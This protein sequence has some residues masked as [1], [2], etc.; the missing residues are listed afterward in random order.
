LLSSA[1]FAFKGD[2]A[3]KLLR[4]AFSAAKECSSRPEFLAEMRTEFSGSFAHLPQTLLVA[5]DAEFYVEGTRGA[6]AVQLHGYQ[7]FLKKN[8]KAQVL[9]GKASPSG[10]RFS[11]VAPTLIDTNKK[12][13]VGQSLWQFQMMTDAGKFSFWNLKSSSFGSQQNVEALLKES[14]A[15]YKMYQRSHDEFELLVTK[16]E[17]TI[18]QYLSIRYDAVES[19]RY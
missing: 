7:S 8:S 9:C 5:R 3:G 6:D 14:G 19:S 2:G 10:E 11:L 1:S 4:P 17:G 12:P 15:T 13:R 18:T 16:K